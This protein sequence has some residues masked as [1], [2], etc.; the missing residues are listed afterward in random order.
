VVSLGR[1]R[2]VGPSEGGGQRRAE[3]SATRKRRKG[4]GGTC[5]AVVRRLSVLRWVGVVRRLRVL[6]RLMMIVV[7]AV[8]VV[9]TVVRVLVLC[10][11]R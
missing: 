10:E 5:L 7:V 11:P 2:K 8:V 3:G 9:V 4:W 6:G 1:L